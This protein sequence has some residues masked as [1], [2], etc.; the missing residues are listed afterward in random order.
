MVF[1]NDAPQSADVVFLIERNE[2]LSRFRLSE[3]PKFIDRSLVERGLTDNKFSIVG[4]GGKGPFQVNIMRLQDT[5]F[6]H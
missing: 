1:Q 2:C 6:V 4:Y 5:L 3:L